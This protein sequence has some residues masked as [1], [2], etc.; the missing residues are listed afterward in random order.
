[1]A[2]TVQAGQGQHIHSNEHQTEYLL[3]KYKC[4]FEEDYCKIKDFQAHIS[5][6]ENASPVFVKPRPIPYAPRERVETEIDR[7]L[8]S[9]IIEKVDRS[10]WAAPVVFVPKT[11]GSV[12]L[13]GDYKVTVNTFVNEEQ[14]PLPTVQDLLSK[15]A[16]GTLF[17][18]IDLTHA[19][20]QSELDEQ[21]QYLTINTHLGLFSYKRLLFGVSSAPSIFQKVMD[22]VLQGIPGVVCFFDDIL[23]TGQTPQ[24]HMNN[25]EEVLQ[26]LEKNGISKCSF[27]Q[28]DV[29]YLGYKIDAEELHPTDEKTEAIV[30]APRPT[31]VTELKSYLGLLN[32]YGRL[33]KPTK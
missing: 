2:S 30:N 4:V 22:Q 28:K 12:R 19:Y 3:N 26:R 23:V 33:S 14:Y 29:E 17:S 8:E 27:L 16:G 9:E 13:C 20:Q 15:L 24:E 31:N 1:M 10:E 21:S 18:K 7:L 6:S 32:Y 5:V 25:L 11:D